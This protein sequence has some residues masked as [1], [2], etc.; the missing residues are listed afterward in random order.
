M[1]KDNKVFMFW[2]SS[3]R[4]KPIDGVIC[5]KSDQRCTCGAATHDYWIPKNKMKKWKKHLKES[6]FA[7]N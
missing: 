6:G 3:H 2:H 7:N 4:P 1:L 5:K